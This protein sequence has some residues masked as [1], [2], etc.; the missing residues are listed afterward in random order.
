MHEGDYAYVMQRMDSASMSYLNEI[1]NPKNQHV[2]K[3]KEIGL[4]HRLGIT[5]LLFYY[6]MKDHPNKTNLKYNYF[7]FMALNEY[8]WFDITKQYN[9]VES[10]IK[11]GVRSYV[12]ISNTINGN[13]YLHWVAFKKNKDGEFVFDL[14]YSLALMESRYK[15]KYEPGMKAQ[16]LR[17]F[18][19][20]ELLD[21][22]WA[23]WE[24]DPFKPHDFNQFDFNRLKE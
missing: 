11:A 1:T 24:L 9:I 10:K 8:A 22:L 2:D 3:I 21:G 20:E 6:Q 18:T 12:P 14:I 4:K 13:N 15:R 5:S 17:A 16:V 19:Q 23:Q 7:R